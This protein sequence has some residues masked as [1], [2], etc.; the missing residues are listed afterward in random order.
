M[1][2]VCDR[3]GETAPEVAVTDDFDFV[4][5]ACEI[6]ADMPAVLVQLSRAA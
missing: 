1:I 3:C 4:C 6:A 2:T 5:R